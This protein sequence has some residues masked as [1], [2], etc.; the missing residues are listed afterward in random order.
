MSLTFCHYFPDEYKDSVERYGLI[1]PGFALRVLRSPILFTEMTNHYRERCL[2]W[3]ARLADKKPE[4]LTIE[5]IETAIN[6]FR[7]DVNGTYFIYAFRYPLELDGGILYSG[8]QEGRSVCSFDLDE[9]IEDG[10]VERVYWGDG[11][12]RFYYETISPR[13][14]FPEIIRKETRLTSLTCPRHIGI[15]TR[16]GRIERKYLRM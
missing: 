13:D 4:D 6:K 15:L 8:Y 16:N 10:K 1:S 7:Q 12:C 5:E 2:T 3:D 14:Y 9:L 11:L